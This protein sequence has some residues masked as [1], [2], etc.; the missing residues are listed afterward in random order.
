MIL[1][2]ILEENRDKLLVKTA[3]LLT[4]H[5]YNQQDRTFMKYFN[6]HFFY[7]MTKG[8]IPEVTQISSNEF[9]L[10]LNYGINK[11]T[12]PEMFYVDRRNG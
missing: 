9:M 8:Y 4:F 6:Q 7:I 11:V 5:V 3:R 12:R 2:D 1:E 10:Q